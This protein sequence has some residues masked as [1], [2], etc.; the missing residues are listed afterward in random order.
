MAAGAQ[1]QIVSSSSSATLDLREIL[2]SLPNESLLSTRLSL[3][4][5]AEYEHPLNALLVAVPPCPSGRRSPIFVND[6]GASVL[7]PHDVFRPLITSPTRPRLKVM[8]VEKISVEAWNVR[9]VLLVSD[10]PS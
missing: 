2:S 9:V 1:G 5:I 4:L 7:H 3:P 6:I 10:R 8:L